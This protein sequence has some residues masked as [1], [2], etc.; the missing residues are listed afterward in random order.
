MKEITA[1]LGMLLA[2]SN[3]DIG[4]TEFAS[5]S[6]DEM[7][8][9]QDDSV[10]IKLI[11]KNLTDGDFASERGAGCICFCVYILST[12]QSSLFHSQ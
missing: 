12:C 11:G 8:D 7:D 9:E 4:N 5:T 1:I 6:M 3:A 2:A 10:D